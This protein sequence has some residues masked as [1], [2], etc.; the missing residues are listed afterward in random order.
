[1]ASRDKAMPSVAVIGCGRW[2]KNLVRNFA[3]LGALA[4]VCDI[5]GDLAAKAASDS[6][7]ASVLYWPS[8]TCCATQSP[9]SV[10]EWPIRPACKLSM[11]SVVHR[12]RARSMVSAASA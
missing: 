9:T 6:D 12:M 4:A 11:Y 2:G 1:M 10:V 8:A 5:D 7:M 3:S